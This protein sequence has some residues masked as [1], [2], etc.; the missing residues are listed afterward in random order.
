LSSSTR[1]T[2]VTVLV[3]LQILV[4]VLA[5]LSG[6]AALFVR[7]LLPEAFPQIRPFHA[8]L[9]VAGVVFVVFAV[10]DF[11][12]AYGLWTG[13]KWGWVLS[14]VL[15]ILGVISAVFSLFLRPRVGQFLALLIDLAIILYLMQP[16]VQA[17]F[18]RRPVRIEGT[19]SGAVMPAE[20][21]KDYGPKLDSPSNPG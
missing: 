18:G 21:P 12:V 7:I 16:R 4:G 20:E 6:A 3:A 15:S 9:F 10:L 11:V 17:Y 14:L 19:E 1:P 2:S 13:K 8:T 5:L